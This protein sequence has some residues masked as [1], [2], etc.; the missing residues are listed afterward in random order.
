MIPQHIRDA[1]DAA[2]IPTAQEPTTTQPK[3]VNRRRDD[4]KK[5]KRSTGERFKVLN[6]FVDVGMVGLSKVEVMAWLVLY[7]DTRDGIACTS[8]ADIAKRSGCSK[9]SVI[10]AI[11]QLKKRG[12]LTLVYRGGTFKGANRYRVS[13]L[14]TSKC[15]QMKG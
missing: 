13:P 7:R 2:K 11:N 5:P 14:P 15:E 12:L 8:M 1:F 4:R 6:T 9:R 10:S 3:T